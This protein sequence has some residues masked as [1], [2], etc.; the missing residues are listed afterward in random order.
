MTARRYAPADRRS[1]GYGAAMWYF[2]VVAAGC[3]HAEP[4]VGSAQKGPYILGSSVQVTALDRDGE[5]TGESY[6]AETTSNLGRF[7]VPVRASGNG[8]QDLLAFTETGYTLTA[9]VVNP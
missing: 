1:A 4:V 2:L 3:Q 9:A 6:A 7:S 5:P 8:Q